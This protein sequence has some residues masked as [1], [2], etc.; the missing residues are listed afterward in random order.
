[1]TRDHKSEWG[2]TVALWAIIL[3]F[4]LGVFEIALRLAPQLIGLPFLARFDQDLRREIAA[5]TGLP[6]TTAYRIMSSA[7]R[8][9]GGRELALFEPNATYMWPADD[10]D[11]AVGALE[12]QTSDAY[13]FCNPPGAFEAAPVDVLVLGGSVPSCTGVRP[14]QTFAAQL[15]KATNLKAYNMTV[16]GAGPN[17]Y[18]EVLRAFGLALKP[19]LVIMAYAES[20]DIRDCLLHQAYVAKG[21]SATPTSGTS[22]FNPM[23][24]SYALNFLYAGGSAIFKNVK[25]ASSDDFR[26]AAMVQGKPYAFNTRNGDLDEL[27]LARDL[28]AD[29][30]LIESCRAPLI[31]FA[32]LSKANGFLPV[33]MLVPAAYTSYGAATAFNTP[34]IS[35][36]MANLHSAQRDWLSAQA[37]DIGF[38]FIDE[39]PAYT[40]EIANR[41]AV[42]FPSN[43]HFTADGQAALAKTMAPAITRLIS[44]QP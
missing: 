40:A 22:P 14:D 37:S 25:R 23:R 43:V 8:K 33:V 13:G 18:V 24:Y 9:D 41:P 17:D 32:N 3:V 38:T 36:A 12:Q 11:R 34:G 28:Q 39:T 6:T 35:L 2:K 44:G 30:T 27:A 15:G 29:P 42:F 4:G 1:M 31:E 20:N 19:R 7:Q 10:D 5:A 21:G 16:G 26:F